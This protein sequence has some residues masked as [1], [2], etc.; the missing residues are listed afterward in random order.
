M[1]LYF[2]Y[3]IPHT[4]MSKGSGCP[5]SC[6]NHLLVAGVAALVASSVVA[7]TSLT[8]A[9]TTS[10]G[11]ASAGTSTSTGDAGASTATGQ[12][13]PPPPQP[14][15][16]CATG[17]RWD[18][19]GKFWRCDPATQQSGSPQPGGDKCTELFSWNATTNEERCFKEDQLRR[20]NCPGAPA[21]RSDCQGMGGGGEPSG[22]ADVCKAVEMNSGHAVC[23]E[24]MAW[25][26]S[27]EYCSSKGLPMIGQDCPTYRSQRGYEG[28]QTYMPRADEGDWLTRCL[29]MGKSPEKC[30]EIHSKVKEGGYHEGPGG[31]YGESRGPGGFPGPFGE[32]RGGMMPGM[33]RGMEGGFPGMGHGG[34]GG[35]GPGMMGGR[36]SCEQRDDIVEEMRGRLAEM[37]EEMA[38]RWGEMEEHMRE[39]AADQIEHLEEKIA[40]TDDEKKIA[41]YQKKIAKIQEKIEKKIA[42]MKARMEKQMAKMKARM[43]KEIEKLEDKECVDEDDVGDFGGGEWGDGGGIGMMA[44]SFGPGGGNSFGF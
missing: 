44:P 19:G 22:G 40:D 36:M 43:E 14:S 13:S 31:R 29:E 10:S 17:W 12:P 25:N 26:G 41:K 11:D 1:S 18:E 27:P 21:P 32:G 23:I 15:D 7:L 42:K 16:P 38:D 30:E 2:F 8:V 9:E 6:G 3:F 34:P 24:G 37:D 20:N 5:G 35:F 33:G 28:K 39:R 4:Y